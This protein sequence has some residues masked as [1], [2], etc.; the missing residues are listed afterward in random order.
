MAGLRAIRH[1][2]ANKNLPIRKILVV[3]TG[4]LGDMVCTTPVLR[5]LKTIPNCEVWVLGNAINEQIL[6]HSGLLDGYISYTASEKEIFKN[7]QNHNFDTALLAGPNARVLSWLYQAGIPRIVT[8]KIVNGRSPFE[9]IS[10]KILAMLTIQMPHSMTSYAPRE[11]LRLLEPLGITTDDTYKTLN[12]SPEARQTLEN[13]F[14]EHNLSPEDRV[15]GIT[16]SA[17]NKIKLWGAE[18]FAKLA[19]TLVEHHDAKIIVTGSS[20][21]K[22]EVQAMLS[23]IQHKDSVIDTLTAFSIDELKALIARLSLF[24]GVDTGPIYIAEAFGVPTVDIVG[25]MDENNQPPRGEKHRVVFA[26]V[27]GRPFLRVM[28]ARIYDA[29]GARLATDKISVDMVM[30]EVEAVLS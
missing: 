21:D 29:Q 10:Y 30:R 22:N 18:K 13:F 3:Q 15:I 25:P 24:I 26:D 7:I 14:H 20:N 11:Y 12:F 17:G 1:G 5:A 28:N 2:K 6:A 16:P 19:D 8:P 23:H 4:K 9:T 27:P